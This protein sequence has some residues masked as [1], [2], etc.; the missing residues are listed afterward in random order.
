MTDAK[1][2]THT[3]R[4]AARKNS[5]G[6]SCSQSWKDDRS[7]TTSA[8]SAANGSTIAN[9]FRRARLTTSVATSL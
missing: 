8:T 2:K 3:A 6:D 7:R 9:H 4:I 5:P 1:A